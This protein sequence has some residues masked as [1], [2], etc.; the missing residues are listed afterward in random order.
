MKKF[1]SHEFVGQTRRLKWSFN[2][3]VYLVLD[4]KQNYSDEGGVATIIT[5][6]VYSAACVDGNDTKEGVDR[7]NTANKSRGFKSWGGLCMR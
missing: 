7:G 2:D 1:V 3:P 4:A 5:E 6:T